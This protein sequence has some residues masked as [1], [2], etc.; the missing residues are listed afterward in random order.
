MSSRNSTDKTKLSV[1]MNSVHH[2]KSVDD[3]KSNKTRRSLDNEQ[4]P[5]NDCRYI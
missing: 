1:G 4:S 2:G 5:N 3:R